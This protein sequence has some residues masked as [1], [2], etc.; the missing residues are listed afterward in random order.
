MANHPSALKRQ[1]QAEKKR[2]QYRAKNREIDEL[3][4][5]I[6]SM[7]S[8]AAALPLLKTVQ[9]KIAK[10]AQKAN[11]HRNTAS[12]AIARLFQMVSAKSAR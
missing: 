5:K 4:K 1:R 11:W 9:S 12:R 2:L 7:P 6:R 3:V 10:M 8:Q